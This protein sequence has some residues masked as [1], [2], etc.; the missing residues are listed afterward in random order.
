MIDKV[1]LAIDANSNRFYDDNGFLHVSKC[2]FTKAQ[3]VEYLGYEIPDYE[4]RGLKPNERYKAYRPPEELSKPNTV[5]SIN[6]IPLQLNHHAE[7]PM[8]PARRTRVGA[9]G[10]NA[11]WDPPYLKNS[12]VVFDHQAISRIKD[13]TMKELSLAYRYDPVFKAGVTPDGEPYDFIMTNIS[14]NH[15]ALVEEGRAGPDV[16]VCDNKPNNLKD[17]KMG[18][19]ENTLDNEKNQKLIEQVIDQVLKRLKGNDAQDDDDANA[20]D[21]EPNNMA[22]QDEDETDAQDDDEIAAND[23]DETDAQDDD[24]DI[25]QDN[26]DK[27]CAEDDDDIAAQ[28]DDETDAQDDDEIAATDDD[29]EELKQACR[30]LIKAKKLGKCSEEDIVNL[31]KGCQEEFDN[32]KKNIA[33]VASD[34]AMRRMSRLFNAALIVKPT[35]GNI[36]PT[37]FANDAAIYRLAL[38]K[39]GCKVPKTASSKT[40]KYMYTAYINGAKHN[41]ISRM[42]RDSKN[43]LDACAH[44]SKRLR[45]GK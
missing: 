19:Q 7:D 34:A 3:V 35:L 24:N 40:L 4:S 5:A 2:N 11:I 42:A 17:I 44:F 1:T 15:L 29:N 26:D 28:D 31:L 45:E 13:G 14:A 32:Q 20:M 10:S 8:E 21:D 6:E 36:S 30:T 12:I 39:E 43:K 38:K 16:M 9:T 41:S 27:D 18:E 25:T 23:D 22:A 37:R 33:Q